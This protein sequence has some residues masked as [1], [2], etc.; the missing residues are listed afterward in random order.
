[1]ILRSLVTN[2]QQDEKELVRSISVSE[3][4]AHKVIDRLAKEGFISRNGT[5][6]MIGDR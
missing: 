3:D 5:T 6:L 1:M 2:P 4:R